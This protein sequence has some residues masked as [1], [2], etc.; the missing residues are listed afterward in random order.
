MQSGVTQFFDATMLEH[1][2]TAETIVLGKRTLSALCTDTFSQMMQVSSTSSV[3]NS[4]R[5]TA[6]SQ[7]SVLVGV[8]AIR[9]TNIMDH[10]FQWLKLI[11]QIAYF[12]ERLFL[13]FKLTG[14]LKVSQACD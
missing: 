5:D 10:S 3:S 1:T 13:S 11:I 6:S 2:Y 12:V 9:A 7:T 8:W 14:F 4:Q